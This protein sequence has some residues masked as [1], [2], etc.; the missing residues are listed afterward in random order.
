MKIENT[1]VMIIL[2]AIISYTSKYYYHHS[3]AFS[4]GV[5]FAFVITGNLM[6]IREILERKNKQ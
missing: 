3:M 5:F 4:V 1:T 6:D 2:G